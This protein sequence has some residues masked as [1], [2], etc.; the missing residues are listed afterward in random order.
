M[1]MLLI[2]IGDCPMQMW[3]V[4][5]MLPIFS[6]MVPTFSR[7]V[8]GS[9]NFYDYDEFCGKSDTSLSIAVCQDCHT[10]ISW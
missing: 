7:D 5:P 10:N 3:Y 8:L 9:M 6:D 1:S 4:N 2:F